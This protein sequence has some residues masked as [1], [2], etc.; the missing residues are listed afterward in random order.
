[1]D[2]S[3]PDAS[4]PWR[5]FVL[6]GLTGLF[7]LGL[8]LI[9]L[10][11]G[12]ASHLV[13]KGNVSAAMRWGPDSSSALGRGAEA[14]IET[15][16]HAG[17]TLLARRALKSSN[18]DARALR[19]LAIAKAMT[20]EVAQAQQVMF[21]A[22][23]LSRR[24]VTTQQWLFE[25]ALTARRF[26]Q[27]FLHADALMRRS[28]DAA[29]ALSWQIIGNLESL[30][31]QRALAARLAL[32]PPWRKTFLQMAAQNAALPS[33]AGI[34]RALRDSPSPPSDLELSQLFNRLVVTDRLDE[35]KLYWTQLTRFA[36][37]DRP[38]YVFNGTFDESDGPTPMN[39]QAL[40][41]PGGSVA[42]TEGEG[43]TLG[44]MRA[45]HDGFS[46]SGPMARE[47]IFAPPGVFKLSAR[48]IVDEPAADQRFRLEV[49]CV[50]G[51]KIAILNLSGVVGKWTRS[52]MALD[53]PSKDCP[54][55]WL[56]LRPNTVDRR[57]AV[58]MRI[59]DI[60][61]SPVR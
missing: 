55:Q 43:E 44:F 29:T 14:L 28:P 46:S 3:T 39:W 15:E 10:R 32:D 26:E 2:H 59:D 11:T 50:G 27:A 38:P 1:V 37:R 25:R 57:E 6:G 41:V 4:A 30:E 40:K 58:E 31:A 17:A 56:Y 7:V 49:F 20:G 21:L 34:F 51:P 53:I 48:S 18:L 8:G 24:D 45:W 23:R 47:I 54:A 16:D 13:A 35:A 5:L 42:W 52:E 33:A 61:I 60:A 9:V 12:L 19:V 22:S 36:P